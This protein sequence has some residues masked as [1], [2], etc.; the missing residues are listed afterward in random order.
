MTPG[1]DGI[2]NRLSL[3]VLRRQPDCAD[4]DRVRAVLAAPGLARGIRE[5]QEVFE[6]RSG[7]Q[8]PGTSEVCSTAEHQEPIGRLK[9]EPEWLKTS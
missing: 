1:M 8:R 7:L 6:N 9:M 3:E 4:A 5:L 2:V